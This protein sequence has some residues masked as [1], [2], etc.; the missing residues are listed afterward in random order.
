MT[1]LMEQGTSRLSNPWNILY[2]VLNPLRKTGGAGFGCVRRNLFLTEKYRLHIATTSNNSDPV[3]KLTVSSTLGLFAQN[4]RNG[5]HPCFAHKAR[6]AE[7]ES[8]LFG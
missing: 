4:I 5:E 3:Q 7:C 6:P 8:S 1:A 2:F